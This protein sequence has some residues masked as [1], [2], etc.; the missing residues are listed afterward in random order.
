MTFDNS[1]IHNCYVCDTVA[2]RFVYDEICE[3]LVT[4]IYS[5]RGCG[6]DY[7]ITFYESENENTDDESD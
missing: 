7:T 1:Q 6:C 5:C 2:V 3:G 4:K